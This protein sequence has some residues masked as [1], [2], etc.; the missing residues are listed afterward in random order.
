MID[1]IDLSSRRALPSLT[2][3]VLFCGGVLCLSLSSCSDAGS[4]EISAKRDISK[5]ERDRAID[6]E[7]T[8][9]ERFRFAAMRLPDTPTTIP[10][11]PP[12]TG[13]S[14]EPAG[15]AGAKLKWDTPEGWSEA[16]ASSM[17]DVNLSFG[18]DGIGE[19]YVA[20]L[21]GAAGGLE[22][23]INRW[24]KQMGQADLS[25]EEIA[26]LPKVD[27]FGV[28][29][30]LVSIDGSFTGMGGS[31]TIDDARMLGAVLMTPNGALFVKM[32][33]PKDLVVANRKAFEDF[34]A[35]L[36]LE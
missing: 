28:P 25:A 1:F 15:V 22:S 18:P 27:I 2:T 14:E 31:A 30:S 35:S 36:S 4:S 20:R 10:A 33:G 19:C 17:R 34:T 26:A 11:N 32:T 23:N 5:F 6:V 3:A 16:P 13:S 24:R 9:K 21:P 29:A 8:D 12:G 7:M